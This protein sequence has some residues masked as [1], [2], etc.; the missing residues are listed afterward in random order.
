MQIQDTEDSGCKSW[1]SLADQLEAWKAGRRILMVCRKRNR[2]LL[3]LNTAGP[4]LP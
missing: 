2:A 1:N 4:Y 3:N